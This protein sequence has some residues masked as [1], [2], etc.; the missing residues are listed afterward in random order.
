M[1]STQHSGV[2]ICHEK[3]NHEK[4]TVVY[5]SRT[6]INEELA[7]YAARSMSRTA[8]VHT[9]SERRGWHNLLGTAQ[10]TSERENWLS[11]RDAH[12]WIHHLRS[13]Q[14][15]AINLFGP[16]KLGLAW[17]RSAWDDLFREVDEV[18][19]EY[20]KVGDP[21]GEVTPVQSRTRVDVY[22]Q[23]TNGKEAALVEVKLTE[24]DFGGCGAAKDRNTTSRLANPARRHSDRSAN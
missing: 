2:R 4:E 1:V 21:L 18:S 15:F 5:W 11:E 23:F 16:L 3:K 13:S 12:H 10:E 17:A 7:R 6:T 22:V 14:A 8:H 19:F 24:P 9:L 20:P